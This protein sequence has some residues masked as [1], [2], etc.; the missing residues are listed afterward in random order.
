[1]R[2]KKRAFTLV[3]LL[4]VIAIIGVLVALLL[5]AVQ[6]AREAARRTS[7]FNNMK[8]IGL[9]LHNYHD[10]HKTFPMGWIGL[11]AATNRPHADGV[12]GWGWGAF[13][14]PFVEQESLSEQAVRITRP[15]LDPAN[16]VARET[17]LK[18]YR[19]PSDTPASQEFMLGQ[20]GSPTTPLVKL[21]SAS[22]VGV[23]GTLE[24]AD[25]EGLP[26]GTQCRSDGIFYH[27]SAT[28]FAHIQDG[29]SNTL[30]VGERSA[31]FGFSTWVGAVQG[32]DDAF[33]R[34]LGTADHAPNSVNG[35]LDDFSSRHP[36]GTNFVLADGSVRLIADTVDLRV[37]RAAATRDGGEVAILD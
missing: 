6:A 10:T 12:P 26:V 11:E 25:C 13:I 3:E 31:R 14:L 17:F 27:L 8:Q 33:A 29:T 28:R 16:Q 7:C 19:C 20:S 22:Y 35:H 23:H 32:G 4:V 30:A 37:Y 18:L 9:A 34:I 36:G 5:P 1:M 15:V 21:A 24:L 2:T